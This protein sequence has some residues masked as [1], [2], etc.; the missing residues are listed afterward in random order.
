[1]P[2]EAQPVSIS[3]DIHTHMFNLKYLPVAGILRRYSR[4]VIP[5]PIARGIE[6]FLIR[7]TKSS[8]EED[9]E[10]RFRKFLKADWKA[11][12]ALFDFGDKSKK[13]QDRIMQPGFNLFDL[14]KE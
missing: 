14:K 13:V 6:K 4:N 3:R 1:M 10:T 7:K 12:T 11:I 2:T 5:L 9:H 8:F